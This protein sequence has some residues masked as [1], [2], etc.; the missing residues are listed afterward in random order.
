[1]VKA[2]NICMMCRRALVAKLH[3]IAPSIIGKPFRFVEIQSSPWFLYLITDYCLTL[4]LTL[5]RQDAK[6]RAELS[7][8]VQNRHFW[9]LKEHDLK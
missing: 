2:V 9:L 5:Q 6:H 3:F 4:K 8:K 1:M 7:A